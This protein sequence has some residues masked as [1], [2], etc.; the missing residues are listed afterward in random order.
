[1]TKTILVVEEGNGIEDFLTTECRDVTDKDDLPSLIEDLIDTAEANFDNCAGLSANQIG[2]QLNVFVVKI[3]G[4]FIP[5]INTDVEEIVNT[6][7]AWSW[8][9]GCLSLPNRPPIK[10]RRSK[11]IIVNYYTIENPDA[12]DFSN[13]KLVPKTTKFTDKWVARAIQ[14]ECD[15]TQGTLI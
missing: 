14:H 12:T 13:I 3:D 15:H 5:F 6:G 4:K 9:E 8:A 7:G 1:M 11:G 10:K 2:V